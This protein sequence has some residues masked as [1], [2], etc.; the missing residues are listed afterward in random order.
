MKPEFKEF[1]RLIGV[2][3]A[4]YRN[5]REMSQS[6]LGE[7]LDCDQSYISKIERNAVGIS[8]DTLCVIAAALNV[9][10]YQLL[11]PKD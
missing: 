4:Y 3:I 5:L 2:N 9:Q 1:Y 10:P 11:K 8:L 6:Q 7:I